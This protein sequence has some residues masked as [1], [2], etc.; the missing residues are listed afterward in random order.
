[1]V[2]SSQPI[3]EPPNNQQA[4]T[5]PLHPVLKQIIDSN[6][7]VPPNFRTRQTSDAERDLL[8]NQYKQEG[9]NVPII[10]QGGNP[11]FRGFQCP[12]CSDTQIHLILDGE[13][14]QLLEG[15]DHE[16]KGPLVK[17]QA[18]LDQ[19][20]VIAYCWKQ[21]VADGV[22][23]VQGFRAWMTARQQQLRGEDTALRISY[24][25]CRA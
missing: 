22:V 19:K 6:W 3:A 2:L 10:G 25:Y 12:I 18:K 15:P 7:R 13:L 11:N 21:Y 20:P 23:D 17:A 16:L 5:H 4:Q 24:S 9:E 14:M 8:L 1:M